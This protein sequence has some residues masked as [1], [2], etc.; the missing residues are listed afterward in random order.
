MDAIDD[1]FLI[2]NSMLLNI[3][4]KSVIRLHHSVP[5][6]HANFGATKV[7]NAFNI[8]RLDSLCAFILPRFDYD[9]LVLGSAQRTQRP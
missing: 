1:K 6:V 3:F 7:L 8:I 9:H 2:A 4:S 5:F